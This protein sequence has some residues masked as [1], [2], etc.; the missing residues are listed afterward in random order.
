MTFKEYQKAA[1][2]TAIYP[3]EFAVI[4]PTLGLAGEA[5]EVCEKIKKRIR[6]WDCDFSTGIFKEEITKEL[7]D[8]QWY[9]A[10]LAMD[11]GI[12]LEDIAA[13]NI[14]KLQS[15]KERHVLTGSGDER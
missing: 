5:G 12:D 15:R 3:K 4:Y 7:G 13:V 10:N 14:E 11:L 2:S 6:D 1:R 9:I 8:L